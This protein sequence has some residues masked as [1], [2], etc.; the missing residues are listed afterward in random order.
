MPE[1]TQGT[2]EETSSSRYE[3]FSCPGYEGEVY[4]TW[5]SGGLERALAIVVD[6]GKA[7]KTLHWGR[8]Y[9]YTVDLA[10]PF[11]VREV[12]VKQFRNQGRVNRWKRRRQGSKAAKSW[13]VARE[14]NRAGVPT[15]QPI[16]WVESLEEEGP[17]FFACQH[18]TGVFESRHFFRALL[19]DRVR[20]E[21][22][23]INKQELLS[24]IAE[25]A[26]RLHGAGVW[27]RD[28]SIG[29]LLIEET[30]AGT[31]P[32]IYIID[33][34][35]A[36][37]VGSLGVWRRTRDL[38][39]LPILN[40]KDR[41]S[42][43]SAYWREPIGPRTY[44]CLLFWILQ[45]GFLFKH[46]WKRVVREPL[47]ALRK[48]V[49]PRGH[50][51]HIPKPE[52]QASSRDKVVWDRLS[53]QPH[54]HASQFERAKVRFADAGSH[55]ET[56]AAATTAVPKIWRR[57][58]R[59]RRRIY[60]RAVPWG[61]VGV[62]LRPWPQDPE[63]LLAALEAARA[64]AVLLRLHPWQA[65][66]D[67]EEALA[68]ELAGRGYELSFALPQN[69]ELVRDPSRWQSAVEELG[70][71]FSPYG[72]HFQV[73]QAIN[74]SK[75][76]V[77]NSR[78]YVELVQRAEEV[79]RR[80]SEIEILGPAV[81]DFEPHATA[82]AVNL[83]RADVQFDV[84]ASLL[85]VDRRGAPENRQLGFDSVD[86]ALLVKAIAETGRNCSPRSW[87]TEVNWPLW[88]G[89]HSPAGR[90]VAVDEQSQANYL[91]RFFVSLFAAGAAERIYWWQLI[92]K[93]YGLVDPESDGT[94][95][96]RPSLT[97]MAVMEE[98]IRGATFA[99]AVKVE[100]DCRLYLFR[101]TGL[102]ELLVGWSVSGSAT[103]ALPRPAARVAGRDGDELPVP[104]GEQIELDEAPRYIVLDG[105]E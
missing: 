19:A 69:R 60:S 39:R 83:K 65:E 37:I 80:R 52:D 55:L 45:Q 105:D 93:G 2:L 16:L 5:D 73:G 59:L 17:S 88:E 70:E 81:I 15:P 38:C 92:A 90:N 49:V 32:Q 10:T 77:W 74:R 85:Y 46:W 103:A 99:R 34:N 14:L 6:P 79:L 97:A 25:L 68:R 101:T 7:K 13:R 67:A 98:H 91:V 100:G 18:L 95:R 104:R 87:I 94:L 62:A 86:K 1:N 35:R 89:P 50:H 76:G 24:R 72:R 64:R 47:R 26:R 22:P 75:W 58:T 8:N 44:R 27:H 84:L 28:L 40:P 29:N 82:A 53:D 102:R 56:L 33:L 54:Q 12:A 61:A 4:G 41:A 42:F 36:R 78:E 57:Y 63:G 31:R 66:H 48:R 51:A 30:A 71:R 9:L 3:R 21:F 11:G 23:W 20:E 96:H 43:L